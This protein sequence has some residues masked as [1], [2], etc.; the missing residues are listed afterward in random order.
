[1]RYNDPMRIAGLAL[2]ASVLVGCGGIATVA[3]DASVDA[4][5]EWTFT[6]D[7]FV[8]P[9]DAAIES[10]GLTTPPVLCPP[11]PP[12]V[13]SPCT[14]VNE[15]CEYGQSWWLSCNPSVRCG[16]DHTW[17]AETKG[18]S[19]LGDA[20][21][22]PPTYAAALEAGINCPPADC[23]YPEGHCTCLG[24]CGGPPPPGPTPNTFHCSP[25]PK[26]CPTL[27]PRLGTACTVENQKCNYDLGCCGGTVLFCMGGVWLGGPTPPCL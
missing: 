11:T 10:D 21:A 2:L 16:P 7:A 3:L 8:F 15:I 22:C 14:S 12:V 23:E 17:G 5:S 1:M 25:T 9:D 26:G 6:F 27:R 13:G 19:C 4:T 24:Y 18:S 20:A